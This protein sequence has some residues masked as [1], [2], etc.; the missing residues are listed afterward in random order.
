MTLQQGQT[1]F[2]GKIMQRNLLTILTIVLGVLMLSPSLQAESPA[3]PKAD[4]ASLEQKSREAY[5]A[6]KWV[7]FY[8]ANLKLHQLLPYETGY[9]VNIVKACAML[10]R[11]STAYHYMLK[12]QQQGA[13]YDFNADD[14]TRGIR[15]TEA[16][17]HINNLLKDAGN[18]AGE[19]AVAFEMPGNAADYRALAW[20]ESRKR[21]LVGT[22]REGTLLAVSA[23]GESEVLLKA[24]DENG[25]WS[26]TGLSV[27]VENNRLWVTS[28]ASPSFINFTVADKSHGALFELDLKTLETVGRYNVPVDGLEHELGSLA[29][30]Q[31]GHVYVIDRA[32]PIIYTKLPQSDRLEA[33]FANPDAGAF[34]DIAV[35][36]DNSRV[37]VSDAEKGILVIDP[38]AR[39]ARMLTGPDNM[40]LGGIES[41]SYLDHHLYV[42]QGRFSP[43]RIIRLELDRSGAAAQSISPMAIAL[44]G[45]DRPGVGAIQ[46]D[47]L[48]YFANTGSGDESGALLMST[49][50]AAGAAS[51]QPRLDGLSPAVAPKE[52]QQN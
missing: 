45:F 24:S 3:A 23:N 34:D 16:Y 11:K 9:V 40:N 46:G 25:L 5:G 37:F 30:S 21:F 38:N 42:I 8:S 22:V 18:P 32:T 15:D 26:I 6:E 4:I 13:S 35:T 1:G 19:G 48:F 20:D 47:K 28:A 17:Q 12:L 36:P 43:Q 29:V 39:Q 51:V 44:E 41:V 50:L 7:S 52:A 33:F 2:Q 49:P 10:D 14:E 31:D 27:D